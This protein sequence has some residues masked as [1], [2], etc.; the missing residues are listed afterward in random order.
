MIELR[1]VTV[2]YD[3]RPGE[4]DRPGLPVLDGVDLTVEEGELMLV[5]GPTGV[6]KST[7][8]GVV[9][10]LV[11]RF[12]GGELAGDVLL[13]G[14]SILHTPPRERAHVIGYVGQDP[15]AGFVTDTAEEELAFGMEQLGLDAATMRR[16][17]EET[18]DLLGI[19]HLRDRDLRSL[20]GGEQQ[21]VAIGAV[22]TTHPR[23]LV[24]DEPTSALDPTAAE[25]V[26]AILTRLVHDLGVSV[27]LAE[28]R[29]ER[30]VPFADRMALFTG[31]GRVEVGEPADLLAQSPVVP[32]L[33]ELGRAAGW[34][35]LP[36]TTREAKRRARSLSLVPPPVPAPAASEE[37]L[38]ADDVSVS[39]G[40][41]VA[42]REVSCRLHAGRITA[43]MGRNGS[44]KSTL[45]WTL[46]GTRARRAG[47][48]RV[49]A[50]DPHALDPAGRRGVVGLLPQ[51][52]SD[53]LYLESVDAECAAGGPATRGLLDRLVPGIDGATHPRDLSEGQRLALAL[54]LVLAADPQVVLL[55]EPTRGLDYA[56]KAALATILRELADEGRAVFVATHDVEFVAVAA[57]DVVVLAEGEVV[58]SGEVHDVLTQSPAFAPQVT[59]VLGAPWLRVAEV[60]AAL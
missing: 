54:A 42:L 9:T 33:V 51:T 2:R 34:D 1:G 55:D 17:V 23:L 14:V 6:G 37:V 3:A 35:P 30:V 16:R 40:S 22:L 53:L 4:Q 50:V 5:S 36:L 39:H 28:H 58:S 15:A 13:D 57:D 32:P 38:A 7:L 60:V 20:S 24:L 44:G 18:L 25:E 19:A 11:P 48:V 8:L 45:L 47:R 46:Q 59:K 29:L 31:A 43:L 49:G 26:L 41:R 27:L 10:G 56:A 21:R 52:A 12:S